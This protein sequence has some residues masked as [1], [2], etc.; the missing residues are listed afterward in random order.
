MIKVIKK[1][2]LAYIILLVTKVTLLHE[3]TK[4]TESVKKPPT[5]NLNN[6]TNTINNNQNLTIPAQIIRTAINTLMRPVEKAAIE[7][8]NQIDKDSIL[9][10]KLIR[11]KY[12][13]DSKQRTNPFQDQNNDK[14]AIPNTLNNPYKAQNREIGK[15]AI[16]GNTCSYQWVNNIFT[17]TCK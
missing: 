10:G 14:I 8:I 2:I 9:R 4:T 13:R 7:G 6:N 16:N 11:E 5:T 17:K 3:P 1:L 12:L 15:I